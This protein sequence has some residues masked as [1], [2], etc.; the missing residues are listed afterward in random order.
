MTQQGRLKIG[1]SFLKIGSRYLRIGPVGEPPPE[2]P[3]ITGLSGGF[4]PVGSSGF[5]FVRRSTIFSGTPQPPTAVG[6]DC[7]LVEIADSGSFIAFFFPSRT[8]N[9]VKIWK[10][11]IT[12]PSPGI[13]ATGNLVIRRSIQTSEPTPVNVV[14]VIDV[15]ADTGL[16]S[17]TRNADASQSGGGANSAFWAAGLLSNSLTSP[18]IT[19]N[20]NG[21]IK[22][23][24]GPW[25]VFGTHTGEAVASATQSRSLLMA[26]VLMS[27]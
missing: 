20:F 2:D 17:T 27:T 13:A 7:T 16:I 22:S 10:F 8:W 4:G 6:T 1:G 24:L 14:G 23:D 21:E 5:I 26:S 25:D 12:G 3:F 18:V 11:V 19:A 15:D 9:W